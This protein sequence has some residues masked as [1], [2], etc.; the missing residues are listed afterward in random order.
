MGNYQKR[1]CSG[2]C[3]LF[4]LVIG[5]LGGTILFLNNPLTPEPTVPAEQLMNDLATLNAM[6]A[7]VSSNSSLFNNNNNDALAVRRLYL[8]DAI[9]GLLIQTVARRGEEWDISDLQQN[10]VGHLEGTAWLG[11]RG[12]TVLVGYYEDDF[13]QPDAFYALGDIEVG[14]QIIVEDG[15]FEN[16]SVY[17]VVD[18]FSTTADDR[19]MVRDVETPRL[20]LITCDSWNPERNAANDPIIVVAELLN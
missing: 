19:S 15:S 7:E 1:G 12:N 18:I 4:S 8:P 2:G 13:G 6:K 17:V 11:D 14:E 10:T 3:F 9:S 20:T 16:R 5:I